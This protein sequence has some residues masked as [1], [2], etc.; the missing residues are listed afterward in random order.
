MKPIVYG[1]VT[2]AILIGISCNSVAQ[3]VPA[4]SMK[5]QE[6]QATIDSLKLEI[7]ALK[8]QQSTRNLEPVPSRP[9]HEQFQFGDP[10]APQTPPDPIQLR[11]VPPYAMPH[12]APYRPVYP[13]LGP[14]YPDH[15]FVPVFVPQTVVAPPIVAPPI[16]DPF[17]PHAFGG[18]GGVYFGPGGWGFGVGGLQFNFGHGHGHHRHHKHGK[19]HDD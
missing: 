6:L 2:L 4:D 10:A 3:D 13:D 14:R 19:H 17:C 15:Q 9:Q 18:S 5:L 7:E 1:L 12:R 11:E 8:M 16:V